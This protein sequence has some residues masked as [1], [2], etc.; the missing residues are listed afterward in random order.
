MVL[1]TKMFDGKSLYECPNDKSHTTK[2]EAGQKITC[3]VCKVEMVEVKKGV[4]NK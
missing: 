3:E 4:I 1:M 2:A